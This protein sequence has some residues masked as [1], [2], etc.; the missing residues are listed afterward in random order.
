MA[1]GG[2]LGLVSAF[3]QLLEKLVLLQNKDALL[4]CNF[5]SVF[6]CSTVLNAWQSSL[7]GF[8]NAL[9]CVI[10]FTILTTVAVTGLVT[11]PA[12]LPRGLRLA[13]H[14]LTVGMLGFALWFMWQST[15][16]IGAICV[17]CLIC[18]AGLLLANWAW[19]R[20]NAD[21]LPIGEGYRRALKTFISRQFDSVAWL[22][23]GLLVA[24][25][26]L[27]QFGL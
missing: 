17:F 10:L 9:L 16:V 1:V 27:V 4:P 26:M 14:G 2:A 13:I 18:L 21:D 6:N 25:A 19:L 7:F 11:S 20:L 3:L 22:G 5:N 15:Y 23:L 12:R 24:L 8:P